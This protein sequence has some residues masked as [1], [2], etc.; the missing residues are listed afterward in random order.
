[1]K[2]RKGAYVGMDCGFCGGRLLIHKIIKLNNGQKCYHVRGL[3]GLAMTG[4]YEVVFDDKA[5]LHFVKKYGHVSLCK[6]PTKELRS[7]PQ[8][9]IESHDWCPLCRNQLKKGD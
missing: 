7:F 2:I 9:A 1:M 5:M 6:I 8:R 4:E 3:V